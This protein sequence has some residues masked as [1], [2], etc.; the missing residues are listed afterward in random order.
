[1]EEGGCYFVQYLNLW[2]GSRKCKCMNLLCECASDFVQCV[3]FVVAHDNCT[4]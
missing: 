1:V 3:C 4:L 2:T